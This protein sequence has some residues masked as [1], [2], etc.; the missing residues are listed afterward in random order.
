VRI[1]CV[2]GGP[3]GLYF[4][5]LVKLWG[6]GNDVT[7]YERSMAG[8]A[9]GGGVTL[10]R[11]FLATLARLDPE[12][13]QQIGRAAV[14]W[15]DQVISYRGERDVHHDAA[16][17]YG[18]SLR[19]LTDVLA[20]RAARTGV[21]I[22]YGHEVRCAA[23]LRDA[24]LVIAADGA[25]STLRSSQAGFGSTV[26]EGR[27]KFAWL[28]TSKA[29]D[30]STLIFEQTDAGWIWAYAFRYAPAASTFIVECPPETWAGLGL[31]DGPAS[32]GLD[33]IAEIFAAHLDGHQLSAQLPDGTD[34]RW[35]SFQTVSNVRWQHG[36]MALAGDSAHAAHFSAWPGTSLAIDD[37]VALAELMRG[38]PCLMAA[39]YGHGHEVALSC[40]SPTLLAYQKQRQAAV[41]QQFAEARRSAALLENLSRYT[42]LAPSHFAQ[43]VRAR[44]AP[45]L[46]VLPPRVFGLLHRVRETL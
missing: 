31:A 5:M 35:L 1:A 28:G 10:E 11:K 22:Q 16:P 43:A 19:R 21:D 2:G 7:V 8:M 30:A 23:E 34:A 24:D 6:P 41:R 45:L 4:A 42:S 25:Q 14:R 44:R 36:R 9:H 27:N 18:V 26:T 17:S 32:V 3:A 40:L 33:K 29:F 38:E 46:P 39:G 37:V 15:Q 12:T 13:A 20:A